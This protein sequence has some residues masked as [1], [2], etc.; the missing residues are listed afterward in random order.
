MAD[1]GTV[2]VDGKRVTI[3]YHT[4]TVT[5]TRK[6][7]ETQINGNKQNRG[8]QAVTPAGS[9]TVDHH[10]IFVVDAMGRERAFDIVDMNIAVREGNMV[11]V[12]WVTPEDVESGPCIQIHNHDTGDRTMAT[13][14]RI[15]S[16]FIKP[17]MIVWGSTAALVIVGMFLSWVLVLLFLFAPYLYFKRRAL[18]AAKRLL[19]S[20]ELKKLEAQLAR[21][22]PPA[23]SAA[24]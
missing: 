8:N 16:Y 13:P 22:K 15:S 19:A 6:Q 21:V 11:T 23:A 17:N 10:E 7:K 3:C 2:D 18:N 9:S 12:V 5:G 4:G 1:A 14:H 20:S 24:A